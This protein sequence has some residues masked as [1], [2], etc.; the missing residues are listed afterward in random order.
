MTCEEL[1]DEY[2]AWAL[3]IAEDPERT[4]IAEHLARN[5]SE[6]VRGVRSAMAMVTAMS[7]TVPSVE[8]PKHLRDRVVGMVERGAKKRFLGFLLPWAAYAVMAIVLLVVVLPGRRQNPDTAKLAEALS[9]LNDPT[10]KQVTF[11]ETAQPSR[12]RVFVSGGKGVLF[13]G[14]SLPSIAP[15]K[16]FELWVIPAKGNPVPAGTFHGEADA[17]AVYVR[18]GPVQGDAAAVAVT[19]E[20]EGGSPQPTTTPFLVIKLTGA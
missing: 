8:P 7:S 20:P 19:V 18:P 3:G 6:C 1:R 16:T 9:I 14:A 11:G 12:G 13:I 4:E 2:G 15:N 10:A 5:C 17:T